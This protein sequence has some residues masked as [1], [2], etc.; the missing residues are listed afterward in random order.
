LSGVVATLFNAIVM[1]HYLSRNLSDEARRFTSS[2]FAFF[3]LIAETFVFLYLGVQGIN[4]IIIV[5]II[6]L[7]S[8]TNSLLVLGF[9]HQYEFSV[10]LAATLLALFARGINIFPVVSL[11]NFTRKRDRQINYKQQLVLWWS[12]LRGAIAFVLALLIEPVTE[13]GSVLVSTT[14]VIVLITT[15]LFG[16]SE[17]YLFIAFYILIL[18]TFFSFFF[19][20]LFMR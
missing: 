5:K 16:G 4:T 7:F 1:S 6:L 18:L 13:N 11:I 20:Q 14:L 3:G 10:I 12:G 19:L 9:P 17:F 2:F 8:H 15:F